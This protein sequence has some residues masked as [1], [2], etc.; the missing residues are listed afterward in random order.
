MT[1]C[2]VAIIGA[3]PYGLSIAAHLR[4]RGI[5]CRIFGRPMDTWLT[6]MPKGM[7]LK[8]EGFASSL[9]DANLEF[10]LGTYCKRE[11]LP[12][13]DIGLPVP[14]E[15]FTKYGLEFQK[16]FVP[17]LENKLVASLSR[18][19]AGFQLQLAGGEDCYARTVIVAV[20]LTHYAYMPPLFSDMPEE[21]VTHSSAHH[22]LDHFQ[23][24]SVAVV[25]AGA[26]ALDLAAL[27]H[28]AGADVQLVAR[29]SSI[30]FHDPPRKRSLLERMRAPN[31]GLA[32]GWNL[33]FCT[34][35]PGVFH[36]MPERF[37]LDFV[38]RTLPPA[39]GWFTKQEVVG[40]VPFHL[41]ANVTAAT[42]RN[43]RVH[44]E[45]TNRAGERRPLVADHV[46]AAT[47]YRVDLRRL[48][49][50]SPDLRSA[51]DD[52][53]QTPILS[54]NFESSVPGLY[55]VGTSAA[56]S[57]G[58]LLRFA[59]GARFAATHLTKRLAR[60]RLRRQVA[61]GR[62]DKTGLE[63]AEQPQ[64]AVVSQ[65]FAPLGHV[66]S[67][68]PGR[69]PTAQMVKPTVRN[70]ISYPETAK[71]L[72]IRIL[73]AD[74]DRRAYAARLAMAFAAAGCEVSAVCTSH[75]PIETI[76]VLHR[77]FPYSAVHPLASLLRAIESTKP[78]LI[79]P[80]DDRAVEHLQQLCGG[81]GDQ[82]GRVARSIE[83]S[84][85]PP[86]SYPVVSARY[87]L[88]ELARRQGIR[89]PATQYLQSAQDL[90]QWHAKQPLPWVL[91]A[92]GT[93][94]GGGVRIAETPQEAEQL[95]DLLK[96]P[97]GLK[98]AVKRLL[99][100]R[101]PFYLRDWWQ[102]SSRSVIAQAYV[103]GRP[104]NCA[105]ACWEGKVLAQISVEVLAASRSTGPASVVRRI[106]NTEMMSAAER[107]AE[108]LHLSGFFGLDFIIESGS[109]ATY[110]LEMNPRCTPLSHIQLGSGT[111]MVGALQAALTG[112]PLPAEPP[113]PAGSGGEVIAY[114]PHT[115]NSNSEFQESSLQ[116]FPDGEPEL[117]KALLRPF[118]E[119]TLLYRIVDYLSGTPA[120]TVMDQHRPSQPVTCPPKTSPA[121]M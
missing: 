111:D 37:R 48:T 62:H 52:V 75:H 28:Q 79:V 63:K 102:G 10:T 13:A 115:W 101:D 93:W 18:S 27:L 35:A 3:G 92:D 64:D 2:N 113:P 84:L 65:A 100:N 9:Y 107:I 45:L 12:Y 40:K 91:K 108:K 98:R 114:F 50:L 116:D 94:G 117:A 106:N 49:F 119:R 44:L 73:L 99:V 68:L 95:L 38:R 36:R 109:G 88:L 20:G 104:A 74:T 70:N 112:E 32:Y 96:D 90:C 19:S 58:P 54:S 31:T 43:S 118:P 23:G 42:A 34:K 7:C 21:F 81:Y 97:C 5:E 14:L 78:D 57:F 85:G 8:S 6:R 15:T 25:G 55:F 77:R 82:N 110:L 47:G 80:C 105:V 103:P 4:A 67:T 39:P 30:R 51:I 72:R 76:K 86:G 60:R 61:I 1:C 26:S 69:E 59:F 83:R 16:R 11:G 33:V 41:G 71:S 87:A 120:A 121:K 29:S 24:R 56:N 89:V 66:R 22:A 46:I 17:Q 53:E